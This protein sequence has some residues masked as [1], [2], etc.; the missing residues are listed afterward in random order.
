MLYRSIR[1]VFVTGRWEIVRVN[2]TLFMVGRYPRDELWRVA[3]AIAAI[4][5]FVGLAAGFIGQRRIDTG[6]AVPESTDPWWRIVLGTAGRLWP[7]IAGAPS[8][9]PW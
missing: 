9:W 6:R 1:F 4:S 5:C 3:V 8:C 7:L 2:L